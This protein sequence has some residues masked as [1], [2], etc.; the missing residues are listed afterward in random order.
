MEHLR[1]LTGAIELRDGAALLLVNRSA[2]VSIVCRDIAP[3]CFRQEWAWFLQGS[4]LPKYKGR[5]FDEPADAL[6]AALD[7]LAAYVEG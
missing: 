3:E 7:S 1:D 5:R 4:Y 6:A 2:R